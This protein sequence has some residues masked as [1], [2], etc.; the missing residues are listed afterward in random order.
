MRRAMPDDEPELR[1]IYRS[2]RAAELEAVGWPGAAIDAFCNQ[3]YDLQQAH[4]ERVYPDLERRV[5][6][7]S[8]SSVVGQ[9]AVDRQ[10]H[11]HTLVDLSVLQQH[12]GKGLGTMLLES[13]T[14]AA[15]AAE[16]PVALTVTRGNPAQ[17]LYE[18]NGFQIESSTEL[19][20]EMRRPAAGK[21]AEV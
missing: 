21:R 13:V 7:D 11:L 5:L 4:Y 18:R 3:Q 12:R 15:D 9:V 16:V 8:S 17:R 6:L 19:D 14:A 10:P 1:T 2:T 20:H